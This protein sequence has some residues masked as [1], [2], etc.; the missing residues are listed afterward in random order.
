M[1]GRILPSFSEKVIKKTQRDIVKAVLDIRKGVEPAELMKKYSACIVEAAC[2]I[3]GIPY[4]QE[5][6][7]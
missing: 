1:N 4:P 2:E 5:D 7:S 3:E 6:I